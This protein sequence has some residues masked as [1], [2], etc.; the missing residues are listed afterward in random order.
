MIDENSCTVAAIAKNEGKYIVEW[1]AHNIVIGFDKIIIYSN[2]TADN[3]FEIVEKISRS[4]DRVQIIDWPSIPETSPQVTA[5]TDALRRVRTEWISFVDIDEFIV[6]YVD[7]SL[8]KFLSR[9]PNDVSSV[10]LNWRNFGSGGMQEPNYDLVTRAF[11]KCA[12]PFWSNHHHFKTIARAKLALDAHIHDI[13]TVS[14]HRVLSDLRPFGMDIRGVS[15]RICHENI[16]INHYQ[17]KTYIEFRE[18]MMRGDA[19]YSSHQV[20]VHSI[21]RFEAL[22]RNEE[23]DTKILEFSD[24]L[25]S[26]YLRLKQIISA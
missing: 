6:P 13:G 26:E 23:S 21:E 18:R 15:D 22:D 14:G 4:D 8:K 9:V 24:L 11:T 1:I 7:K 12:Q 19:N 5:Y 10:H 2:E 3:M 25:D 20:R 16:L 17:S